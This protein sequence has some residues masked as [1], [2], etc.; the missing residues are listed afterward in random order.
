MTN[1]TSIQKT[2]RTCGLLYLLGAVT[3]IYTHV[4][5]ASKIFVKNDWIAVNNNVLENEFLLKTGIASHIA[6][7]LISLVFVLYLYRLFS[8]V[9][10]HLCR[11]LL[12]FVA[13]QIPIVIG[14]ESLRLTALALLKKE[15]FSS[16]DASEVGKWAAVY[17]KTY[18][19]AA[20][21]LQ[22]FFGLW[23]LPLGSLIIKSAY[24]P[25]ILGVLL[26]AAGI[27]YMADSFTYLLFPG[28]R[29]Y[30]NTPAL[31]LSGLGEIS[32]MLWLLIK[33]VDYRKYNSNIIA[34]TQ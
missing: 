31:V 13:V 17:M 24:V 9:N 7:M 23:L 8:N 19:Q 10:A 6:G 11:M 4:Y 1:D 22:V 21:L 20:V 16:T 29:S 15:V 3:A 2:A 30:T 34:Q 25:R 14:M 26:I 18:G 5:V 32:T 27:G 12:L 33:G 28:F